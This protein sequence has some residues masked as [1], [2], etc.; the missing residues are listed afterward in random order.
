[1][2]E[3]Q[4]QSAIRLRLARSEERRVAAL[5]TGFAALDTALGGG[6]ARASIVELF[7]PSSS[8]KTT[9]AFQ[10]VAHAQ[11]DGATAAWIDAEHVFDASYASGLG[12]RVEEMPLAQ[13]VSA[14]EALEITYRLA[15]S[16]AVDL[17]VVDS[18]AALVPQLELESGMGEGTAGL[19]S[20]VLG[21]GLRRLAQVVGKSGTVLV[22]LNQTRFRK[23]GAGGEGETSA[24][25]ASL[26]LYASLR[27]VLDSQTGGRVGFRVLKNKGAAA[28]REGELC[29]L[30]SGEFVK[31][32]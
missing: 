29:R 16:G 26:K 31:S 19:H 9:L 1:M 22:F 32:P 10:I 21:S 24:G 15:A 13:P 20:R 28:F 5:P 4:R 14:E 17:V 18:A 11:Q 6:F 2:T 8:G 25:G 7:G 3:Q 23:Q 30:R 12:V 27:L